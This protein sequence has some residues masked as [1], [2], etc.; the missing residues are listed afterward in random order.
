MQGSTDYKRFNA[1]VTKHVSAVPTVNDVKFI[2]HNVKW[3]RKTA[4][5]LKTD[6]HVES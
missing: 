4:N 5:L 3:M 6:K 2:L 1:P